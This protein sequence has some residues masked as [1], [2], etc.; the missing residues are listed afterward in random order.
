MQTCDVAI[1]GAGPYGLS[2]AAHLRRVKGL[3]VRVFGEPMSFW[4][5]QM[6]RGMLLRSNWTA[7]Q[8]A[9][10]NESLSLEMFQKA[11][12]VVFG[13]PVP[14]ERFVEYGRWYQ[15]Q[16]V[17]DLDLRRVVRV[18]KEAGRFQIVLSHGEGL[19]CERVVIAVGIGSFAWRPPEFDCLPPP[20][21]SHTSEQ[22]DFE[23]LSGKKVLVVGSG[24]SALES[25]ALVRESGGEADIVARAAK[26]HWLQGWLSKTLHHRLGPFVR[27]TLYAPTDVGPAGISQILA[28]PNWV[29]R[30][31]RGA[32]NRLRKRAVR[33]AGA[34][35]LVDRLQGVPIQLGRVVT[36]ASPIGDRVRVRLDDG[37]ERT[38]DHILLGTGYRVDVSKYEFLSPKLKEAILSFD[39]YPVLKSGFE[40]SVDGLHIL[41]APAAWSFGPLMQFVS[42]TRY[43]SRELIRRVSRLNQADIADVPIQFRSGKETTNG[44]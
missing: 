39:G 37:T 42:G 11:R 14:L 34:R 32:Q 4:D 43:A 19:D 20:L 41:G 21:A 23:K 44:D 5:R 40:T 25:A 12:G 35:W 22:R 33:P 27:Q 17:P 31:P 36:T 30:L 28:R 3:E 16:A 29:R 15:S 13:V 18:E 26:I 1:I 8:I 6:P 38:V 10:P 7:T 9:S 24:Q 2:A